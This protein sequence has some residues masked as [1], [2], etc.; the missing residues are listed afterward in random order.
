MLFVEA[1]SKTRYLAGSWATLKRCPEAVASV[2]SRATFWWLND[3]FVR[4]FSAT[5]DLD[6]LYETDNALHSSKLLVEFR[7]HL[8]KAKPSKYRL[9]F[10]ILKCHKMT[11]IKTVLA[12]LS[13][14][15]LKFIG[16]FLLQYIIEF[17]QNDQQGDEYR[18]Q[19]GY[20]LIAATGLL[21]ISTAV[22]IVTIIPGNGILTHL[23]TGGHWIL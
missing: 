9:A 10:V 21:Y 15:G 7:H 2:F 20:A 4:G 8:A 19:I 12:R 16:P 18:Q 1:F 23:H 22:R 14:I 17:V 3:L 13:I 5:L 6:T 11:F